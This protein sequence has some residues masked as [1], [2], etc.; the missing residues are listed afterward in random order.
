MQPG[1]GG[2]LLGE[3]RADH[4]H[5][6]FFIR[7]LT[8]LELGIDQVAVQRQF[9]TPASGRNQLEILN[10]LLVRVEKL[11]RQTEGLRLVISHAA[12]LEFQV[13]IFSFP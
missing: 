3:T 10:L 8:R 6:P 11:A 2:N 7:K 4:V 1:P 13:H 5:D 12:I 9:K